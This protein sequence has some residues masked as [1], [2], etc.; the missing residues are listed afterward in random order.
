MCSRENAYFSERGRMISGESALM[1]HAIKRGI[2]AIIIYNLTNSYVLSAVKNV[3]VSNSSVNISCRWMEQDK[4]RAGYMWMS[5]RNTYNS[6][7]K[8]ELVKRLGLNTIILKCWGFENVKD[9]L[10][11]IKNVKEWATAAKDNDVHLFIAI[12]WQPY[13]G[14]NVQNYKKVVYDDGTEG[15]AICPLDS[16]LWK[17]RLYE[18]L[19]L[20]AKLSTD[21]KIQID[22]IFLDM[23]IYG[24]EKEPQVRKNYYYEKCDFSDLCFSQYLMHRGYSPPQLAPIEK[25]NRKDWLS[26]ENL[27]EDYFVYLR[28]QIKDRA[29]D[30]RTSVR[31]IN[32]NF[33][34]GIYPQ[35][36]KDNWVSYSLAEGFSSERLPLII[37]GVHSYGYPKDK[38]GDGY[39]FIPK[40]IKQQYNKNDINGLYV[41]GYLLHRYESKVLERNLKQ[42]VDNWDGYWLFN[43]QQLWDKNTGLG[44]L[45]DSAENLINAVATVNSSKD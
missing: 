33:L 14:K 32:P 39:T 17:E 44:E 21:P 40:D 19:L 9:K 38:N 28:N 23:E 25:K 4:V 37:F 30:L 6:P 18:V 29:I 1:K 5:Y 8:M 24:T 15:L 16:K 7:T 22:G 2:I 20:I 45:T 13:P 34:I 43:L 3:A 31:K 36:M 27:F 42:S 35:P 11:T 26:K 10:E 41:A 12:N